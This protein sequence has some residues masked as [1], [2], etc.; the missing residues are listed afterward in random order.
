MGACL[1]CAPKDEEGHAIASYKFEPA[2][3]CSQKWKFKKPKMGKDSEGWEMVARDFESGHLPQAERILNMDLD[4]QCTCCCGGC[5]RLRGAEGALHEGGWVESTD[6]FLR[7][8]GYKVK[9]YFQV[10]YVSNGQHGGHHQEHFYI[11]IYKLDAGP[12]REPPQV[13]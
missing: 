8:Y 12:D 2:S 7:P 9:P 13:S 4:K 1:C 10:V 11:V 5:P 3:L 6:R